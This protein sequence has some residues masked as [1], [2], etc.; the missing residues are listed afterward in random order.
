MF[1]A[2][3]DRMTD[4][5]AAINT[6]TATK[7]PVVLGKVNPA[8]CQHWPGDTQ[9]VRNPNRCFL[10]RV[11]IVCFLL[12]A[13]W[14]RVA[15]VPSAGDIHFRRLYCLFWKWEI[16]LRRAAMSHSSRAPTVRA[17]LHRRRIDMAE[18]CLRLT[19]LSQMVIVDV[20][21]S[22]SPGQIKPGPLSLLPL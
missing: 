11:Q 5:V 13:N 2:V 1:S 10:P 9:C 3:T 22:H 8:H 20:S 15:R 18:Y 21:A 16:S 4:R 12:P 17:S 6:K 14:A 19:L 7:L